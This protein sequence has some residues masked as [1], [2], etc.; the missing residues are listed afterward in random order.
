MEFLQVESEFAPLRDLYQER[1][2]QVVLEI[3][4]WDGGSL[5]EWLVTAPA[6]VVAVD[7]E[8]RNRNAY[9]AWRNAKTELILHMGASQAEDAVNFMREHGPYDWVFVDGGHSLWD[10]ETDVENCRPLVSKGGLMILHD[11]QA[12]TDY[13]AG[14]YPPKVVLDS[15][16]D[17]HETWEYIDETPMG[18]AHGIG[19]IQL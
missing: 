7:L 12:G 14:D 8:H 13:T 17:T 10:V 6:K 11:V 15:F 9:E 19:V 3:G 5:R 4:S 16:K 2:P 18:W 1:R